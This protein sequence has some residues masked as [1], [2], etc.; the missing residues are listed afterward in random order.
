MVANDI[1]LDAVKETRAQATMLSVPHRPPMEKRP[2]RERLC[3]PPFHSRANQRE[4]IDAA[5]RHRRISADFL[6]ALPPEELAGAG[7]ILVGG[8]TVVVRLAAGF[9]E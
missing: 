8:E 2:V 6:K 7:N 3:L 5:T 1:I 9:R 4:M